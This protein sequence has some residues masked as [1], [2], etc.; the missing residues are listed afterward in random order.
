MVTAD[1]FKRGFK[2]GIST[3]IELS[4]VLV[5][6]YIGVELLDA[7]GLLNILA[8]FFEPVMSIFGLPGEASLII[9]LSYFLNIYA[10]LGAIA[11]I[12]LDTVQLTT[13]AIMTSIAHS[14][15]TETAIAKKLGVSAAASIVVR[16]FF[17]VLMGILYYR[18]FGW[19]YELLLRYID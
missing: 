16:V 1:T 12:E 15:I 6:V 2:N 19:Y 18:M 14:L 3:L 8:E 10:G 17:S 4:K 13:I 9:I 5:P 11:A 7:S